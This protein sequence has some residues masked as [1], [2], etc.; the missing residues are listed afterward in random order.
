MELATLLEKSWHLFRKVVPLAVTYQQFVPVEAVSPNSRSAAVM[1]LSDLALETRWRE[2][3]TT[4]GRE[5]GKMGR[6][7]IED[8]QNTGAIS[9][10]R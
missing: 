5:L 8:L 9:W 1:A 10:V 3:R 2:L 4:I 7:L 6:S